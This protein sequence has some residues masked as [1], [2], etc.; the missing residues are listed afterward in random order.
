MRMKRGYRYRSCV[1]VGENEQPEPSAVLPHQR[2]FEP[3]PW[4]CRLL[5]ENEQPGP[6]AVLPQNSQRD[7]SQLCSCTRFGLCEQPLPNAVELQ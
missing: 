2:H 3:W 4:R 5:G 7:G 6:Y 1:R